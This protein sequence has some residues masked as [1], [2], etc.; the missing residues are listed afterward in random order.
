M[1]GNCLTFAIY[2][3]FKNGGELYMV[4][5]KGYRAPHFEVHRNGEVHDLEIVR[6]ILKE[7]WYDGEPR[8]SSEKVGNRIKSVQ[9]RLLKRRVKKSKT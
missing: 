8:V 4:L 5:I 9:Y 6:M 2:D 3:F 7:F 1:I